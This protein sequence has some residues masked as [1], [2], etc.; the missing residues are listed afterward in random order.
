[1]IQAV[2]VVSPQSVKRGVPAGSKPKTVDNTVNIVNVNNNVNKKSPAV[3]VKAKQNPGIG[4][5]NAA[6]LTL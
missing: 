1:M 3:V 2:T 6:P 4:Q 5:N